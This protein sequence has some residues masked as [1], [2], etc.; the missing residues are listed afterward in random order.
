MTRL[1]H[2]LWVC[3]IVS[4]NSTRAEII[5]QAPA[6][7]SWELVLMLASSELIL[8]FL[9]RSLDDKN[10]LGLA[11]VEVVE[12]MREISNLSVNRNVELTNQIARVSHI[13]NRI[14]IEP[15]WIKGAVRIIEAAKWS[16]VRPM[17]DL[18]LWVASSQLELATQALIDEGY[19]TRGNTKSGDKHDAP[20]YHEAEAARIEVHHHLVEPEQAQILPNERLLAGAIFF[21]WRGCRVGIP[22]LNDQILNIISQTPARNLPLGLISLA[23]LLEFI[24]LCSERG[25]SDSIEQVR[26]IYRNAKLSAVADKYIALAFDLFGPLRKLPMTVFWNALFFRF[27]FPR[28]HAL[29]VGY[30]DMR[31]YL[32]I[33]ASFEP[34]MFVEKMLRRTR[35]ALER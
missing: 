8:P 19:G 22:S 23:R 30:A 26:K 6:R 7:I 1:K 28:L 24:T 17:H 3:R 16:E 15:I 5:E 11:P 20:L 2:L 13:L 31:R 14:G 32:N 34:R 33:S 10:L 29:W 4:P 12:I 18:D 9:Y 35:D 21:E 25:L 27:C